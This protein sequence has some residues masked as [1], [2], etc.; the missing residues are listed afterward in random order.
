MTKKATLNKTNPRIITV[1]ILLRLR[2]QKGSLASEFAL[3][4]DLDEQEKRFTQ[5]LCYGLCRWYYLLE[6]QLGDL[7]AKPLKNN[8]ILVL[9]K[10]LL[11]S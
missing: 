2:Q 4:N 11:D 6:Y 3:A 8:P 5:E 10:P 9:I 1:K 7:L